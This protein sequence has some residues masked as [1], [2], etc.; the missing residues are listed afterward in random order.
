[1]QIKS[2]VQTSIKTL[3]RPFW[4]GSARKET[5]LENRIQPLKTAIDQLDYRLSAFLLE[6]ERQMGDLNRRFDGFHTRIDE[7]YDRIHRISEQM[8]EA[9]ISSVPI[10]VRDLGLTPT[11]LTANLT[12][13]IFNPSVAW[14][15]REIIFVSRSTNLLVR[16]GKFCGYASPP[17]KSVNIFHH[18]DA[19]LNPI[20]NH[21]LNDELLRLKCKAA[22]Y[23][24]EDLRLFSWKDK[25]WAIAT[26][27]H[28]SA[29]ALDYGGIATSQ[30]LIQFDE[31]RVVD[32]IEL[33]SPVAARFEKNWIP[34]VKDDRLFIIYSFEPMVIY[35]FRHGKMDLLLG[36]QPEGLEFPP[37]EGREFPIR[38]STPL[39][40]YG[41]NYIGLVHFDRQP[42][43]GA[44]NYFHKFIVLNNDFEVLEMSRGFSFQRTGVEFACGLI[45]YDGNLLVS[46]GL[47][48]SASVFSV[49]PTE[50]LSQ[51]V[52]SLTNGYDV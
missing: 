18:Y 36:P 45:K 4:M 3:L 19:K 2:T 21:M 52:I 22:E 20:G 43:G 51:W 41:E 26:G 7:L 1:M 46:Y 33:P 6:V 25:L 35:E 31:W 24:I 27:V 16:N 9:D 28:A 8:I 17:H 48:D 40:R 44:R 12:Y 49:L 23:G 5:R 37:P 29:T 10:L 32:F 15:K 11:Y 30:L 38:G 34:L 42:N 13:P 47:S 14:L 50:Q 39:I